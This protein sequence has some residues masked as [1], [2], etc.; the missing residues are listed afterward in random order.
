MAT[1]N[2]AAS[3]PLPKRRYDPVAR[4]FHWLVVGLLIVQYVIA[5]TMPNADKPKA[6]VGLIGWHVS[7]GLLILLVM[8]LRLGWRLTHPAPPPPNDI[9]ILLQGLARLTQ[10]VF[11]TALLAIPFLGW[12][13]ASSRGWPIRMFGLIP[14]PAIVAKTSTDSELTIVLTNAH[15]WLATAV[16]FV[17]ALHIAGALTHL[18]VLR[19]RTVQRILPNALVPADQR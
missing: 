16:L 7:F 13:M 15:I 11:Y 5:W 17:V 19:D 14:L 12:A 2:L 4:G 1:I 18:L 8:M 3:E 10:V 6:P 9:P